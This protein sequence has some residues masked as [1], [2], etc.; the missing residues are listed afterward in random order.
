MCIGRFVR[1]LSL[2][3]AVTTLT[4]GVNANAWEVRQVRI[5]HVQ[6]EYGSLYISV[7]GDTATPSGCSSNNGWLRMEFSNPNV[8]EVKKEI[9]AFA[10]AAYMAG[11]PVDVASTSAG[12][13]NGYANL[14]SI[15]VGDYAS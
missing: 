6:V 13:V 3:I 2:I 8:A 9:V 15:R 5:K 1:S 7:Q 4:L 10:L 14:A 11:T 12:C